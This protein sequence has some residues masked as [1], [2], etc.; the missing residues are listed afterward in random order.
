MNPLNE[1][2]LSIAKTDEGFRALLKKNDLEVVFKKKTTGENRV[3]HCTHS[4]N[5]PK[6]FLNSEA[7]KK[8]SAPDP[9]GL[10]HVFDT[11]INEWRS[12]YL[13]SIIEITPKD[14]HY[15]ILL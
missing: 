2:L 7:V 9:Q 6:E 8:A 12:L 3:L 5:V 11:D 14:S 13:D 1:N 15:G 4:N 10:V